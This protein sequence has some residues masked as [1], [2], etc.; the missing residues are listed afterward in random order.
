M[1]SGNAVTDSAGAGG[2]YG[3]AVELVHGVR[4]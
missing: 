2:C 3:V 4:R 1:S